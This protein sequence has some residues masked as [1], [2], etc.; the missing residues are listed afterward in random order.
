MTLDA[1]SDLVLW[2]VCMGLA[3]L[4][5]TRRFAGI[6]IACLLIGLAAGLG[7]FRFSSSAFISELVKGAH[8]FASLLAAVA[9]LPILA[10]SIGHPESPLARRGAGAWWLAFALGG[11]GVAVVVLGFKAWAQI[12]PVLSG[13]SMAWVV[14]RSPAG[15]DRAVGAAGVACLFASF[16]AALLMSPEARVLGVLSKTQLLHYLLALALVLICSGAL[17]RADGW[18]DAGGARAPVAH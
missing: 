7:V 9:G 4:S 18:P 1:F 10:F 8:S 12:V 17:R 5:R 13:V 14:I 15:R 6:G 11:L 2:A 16:A 3:W